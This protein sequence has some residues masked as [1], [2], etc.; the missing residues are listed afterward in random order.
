VL[1]RIPKPDADDELIE[2][3]P[4]PDGN[5]EIC[6]VDPLSGLVIVVDQGSGSRGRAVKRRR[7]SP[8]WGSLLSS[9]LTEAKAASSAIV[10]LEPDRSSNQCH[11]RVIGGSV[12]QVV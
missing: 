10:P 11:H 12:R 9:W 8:L 7:Q 3:V 6:F 2:H 1:T 4:N 5:S